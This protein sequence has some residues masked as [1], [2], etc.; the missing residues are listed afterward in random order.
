MNPEL[1][2]NDLPS[3]E[4]YTLIT[5]SGDVIERHRTDDPNVWGLAD[6]ARGRT[7]LVPTTVYMTAGD[8]ASGVAG[9]LIQTGEF[10]PI[11]P[12]TVGQ[13][14]IVGTLH[15]VQPAKF[16]PEVEYVVGWNGA[17]RT[18]PFEVTD[19][20]T[21]V[22]ETR[23]DHSKGLLLGDYALRP[24]GILPSGAARREQQPNSRSGRQFLADVRRAA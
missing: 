2:D 17:A 23:R 12:S 9:R 11:T 15:D 7:P 13:Q 8:S 18:E 24:A 1:E 10:F 20:D 14:V 4:D 16:E 22:T 21:G 6:V 3:P 5:D 19:E